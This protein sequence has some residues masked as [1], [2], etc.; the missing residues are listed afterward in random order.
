MIRGKKDSM[1][2]WEGV[3]RLGNGNHD[4]SGVKGQVRESFMEEEVFY[5]VKVTEN[6][7]N[8]GLK[9]TSNVGN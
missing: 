3:L 2:D 1:G 5:K 7:I 8:W 6:Q 4:G 9:K